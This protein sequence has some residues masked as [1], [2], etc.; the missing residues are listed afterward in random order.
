VNYRKR[1]ANAWKEMLE[2]PLV[3]LPT[4]PLRPKLTRCVSFTVGIVGGGRANLY[5]P[6]ALADSVEEDSEDV[7]EVIRSDDPVGEALAACGGRVLLH[8]EEPA[9][10]TSAAA[11]WKDATPYIKKLLA[12]P[13]PG[14]VDIIKEHIS[15]VDRA[16]ERTVERIS[17]GVSEAGIRDLLNS[18]LVRRGAEG[19]LYP[20]Q[21]LFGERTRLI[22]AAP[23]E[24]KL[25]EDDVVLLDAAPIFE[26]YSLPLARTLLLEERRDVIRAIETVG[27]ALTAALRR[28]LPGVSGEEVDRVLRESLKPHAIPHAAGVPAGGFLAPTLAPGSKDLLEEMSFVS[29]TGGVYTDKY[30]VRVKH[31]VLVREGGGEILETFARL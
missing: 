9:W 8:P 16:L 19:F 22:F 1:R 14:E 21:V 20:T 7:W 2:V 5:V 10:L 26:G 27:K 29:L 28:M 4:S 30:G 12:K 25:R 15:S 3:F 17:P 24:R 6:S 13:F 11:E 23:S 31:L 18:L